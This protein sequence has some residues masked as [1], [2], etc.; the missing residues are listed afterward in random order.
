[1]CPELRIPGPGHWSSRQRTNS[2]PALPVLCC[3][4]TGK[5]R[6][7]SAGGRAARLDM[8]QGGDRT[9]GRLAERCRDMRGGQEVGLRIGH[10]VSVPPKSIDAL[11][12]D[13]GLRL[14]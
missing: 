2:E 9:L 3:Q 6:L 7:S 8:G 12:G 13:P 11:S 4:L 14:G 1:V 5:P 10:A